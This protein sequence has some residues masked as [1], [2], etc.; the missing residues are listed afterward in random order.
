MYMI[1]RK[2]D[3]PTSK[4]WLFTMANLKQAP[5]GV[6]GYAKLLNYSNLLY[7]FLNR[8]RTIVFVSPQLIK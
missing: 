3:T 8:K 6:P 7:I 2:M 5:R 4:Y 1:E